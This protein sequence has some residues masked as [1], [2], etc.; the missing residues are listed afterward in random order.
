MIDVHCHLQFKDFDKT[1]EH[2]IEK[3]K[4]A[5]DAV[6]I[7][8]TSPEDAKKALALRE[9]HPD[10]IY[11]TLGMHPIYAETG[12][13]EIEEYIRF[14][15]SS[16]EKIAGIG[17]IGLDYHWVKEPEKILRMK[18]VLR[19]FLALAREMEL[20]AVIH[21]RNA[22]SEDFDMILSSGA[23]KMVF[24]C[25]SASKTLA[26]QVVG[27]GHL[28]SIATNIATSKNTKKAAKSVPLSA[29]LTETDAPFLGF[30]KTNVPENVSM[31]CGEIANL[32][33]MDVNDVKETTTRNAKTVFGIP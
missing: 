14:I 32:R 17:E 25:W 22:T 1:R 24:H 27:A 12:D 9:K 31:V 23:E 7:S 8:G 10:F 20:P 16:R 19:R 11:V 4:A 28:V 29:I 26:E 13:A 33:G 18:E 3:A 21:L 2:V 6:V 15:R 5:L 30:G